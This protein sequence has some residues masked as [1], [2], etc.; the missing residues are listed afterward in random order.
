MTSEISGSRTS[1]I[2]SCTPTMMTG[3]RRCW[4][5]TSQLIAHAHR[6]RDCT[7]VTRRVDNVVHGV[8][9]FTTSCEPVRPA[10]RVLCQTSIS[11]QIDTAV[12]DN[13]L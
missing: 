7:D 13:V 9:Y 3:S 4:R 6:E 8:D 11:R 2:R 10:T 5:V 1:C 12:G